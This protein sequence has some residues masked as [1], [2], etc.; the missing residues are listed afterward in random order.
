M[1]YLIHQPSHISPHTSALR[2]QPSH[3]SHLQRIKVIDKVACQSKNR[4]GDPFV[5]ALSCSPMR[6][7]V[8]GAGIDAF[9]V[10]LTFTIY[11]E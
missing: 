11:L 5:Y 10:I 3:I 8:R 7:K 2:H 1:S 9:C 6:V 4:P